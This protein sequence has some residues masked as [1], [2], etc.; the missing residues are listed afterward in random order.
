MMKSLNNLSQIQYE[1]ANERLTGY[2]KN[3]Y[4]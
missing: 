3:G 4:K 2:Y 1:Q